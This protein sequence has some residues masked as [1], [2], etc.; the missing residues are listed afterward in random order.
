MVVDHH[1]IR[2]CRDGEQRKEKILLYIFHVPFAYTRFFVCGF[3]PS[4]LSPFSHVSVRQTAIY[5]LCSSEVGRSR[6]T[7]AL[8]K[9]IFVGVCPTSSI[10][11]VYSGLRIRRC[12]DSDR[13]G[14]H[15]RF[16]FGPAISSHSVETKANIVVLLTLKISGC[17]TFL[18]KILVYP[19]GNR[20]ITSRF[21]PLRDTSHEKQRK[22]ALCLF[23]SPS[24]V[25]LLFLYSWCNGF[26]FLQILLFCS[27]ASPRLSLGPSREAPFWQPCSAPPDPMTGGFTVAPSFALQFHKMGS[28]RRPRPRFMSSPVLSDLPRFQAT[29]QALQLSSNSAWNR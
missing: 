5:R 21:I 7:E 13:S 23:V 18:Q 27:L 20:L 2:L 3:F 8:P 15:G 12:G 19:S 6:S 25:R 29:R 10:S 26:L 28:F 22:K 16:G 1:L 11:V 24:I 4:P 9:F 14:K 17:Q